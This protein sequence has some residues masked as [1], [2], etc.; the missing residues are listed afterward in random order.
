M[1]RVLRSAG[2]VLL[3]VVLYMALSVG[4]F[5]A[6]INTPVLEGRH[7]R[8]LSLLVG[9]S[10]LASPLVLGFLV[11]Y[12]VAWSAKGGVLVA[13]AVGIAVVAYMLLSPASSPEA[14]P[15]YVPVTY[16]AL[17]ILSFA[18]GGYLWTVRRRRPP[19][20]GRMP[21][22]LKDTTAEATGGT[23]VVPN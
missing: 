14:G 13:T 8:L 1:S 2:W 3:F 4:V 9:Y 21:V 20:T 23:P 7:G 15:L 18:A 11:G 6:F 5:F 16:S 19:H 17:I 22:P 12:A 10:F